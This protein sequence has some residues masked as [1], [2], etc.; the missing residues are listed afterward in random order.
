MRT[1]VNL[2]PDVSAA[3]QRLRRDE[4]LG[5]S[6]ALNRIARAGLVASGRRPRFKQRT[7]DMGEF[8][9]DVTNVAQALDIIEGPMRR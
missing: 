8:L 2:D 4:G 7:I 1:T 9:V 3:V 5:L 6:D